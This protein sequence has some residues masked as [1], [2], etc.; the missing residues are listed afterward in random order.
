M[1]VVRNYR[2][3]CKCD[4]GGNF[5]ETRTID[6][7]LSGTVV[8][9]F[10]IHSTHNLTGLAMRS[11]D[12]VLLGNFIKLYVQDWP[13]LQSSKVTYSTGGFD[14]ELMVNMNGGK[15]FLNEA[16]YKLNGDHFGPKYIP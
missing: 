2:F 4:A 14:V 3:F 1:S 8:H 7:R 16:L 12:L 13:Y 11:L 15:A 10:D 9:F 5:S 6:R